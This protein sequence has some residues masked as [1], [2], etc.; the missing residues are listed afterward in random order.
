M[1]S[2]D[3]QRAW[4]P[5]RSFFRSAGCQLSRLETCV[6]LESARAVVCLY[7]QEQRF[8]L[9]SHL[10]VFG[11]KRHFAAMAERT[12]MLS[13][14]TVAALQE[15][16]SKVLDKFDGIKVFMSEM[17]TVSWSTAPSK[18]CK[19]IHNH[20]KILAAIL[21]IASN[22]IVS[23]SFMKDVV[24]NLQNTCRL[25]ATIDVEAYNAALRICLS[26]LRDATAEDEF[27]KMTVRA[28]AEDVGSV[29]RLLK[30]L[31]YRGRSKTFLNKCPAEE[32]AST[33]TRARKERSCT[34][35]KKTMLAIANEPAFK[36]SPESPWPTFSNLGSE[37]SSSPAKAKKT[38]SPPEAA[39]KT[40]S[41]PAPAAKTPP[42]TSRV[43]FVSKFLLLFK[44]NCPN[45]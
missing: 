25:P 31:E 11:S 8:E 32:R 36:E 42:R 6:L 7:V 5:T 39:T 17:K 9:L 23:K 33:P 34:T 45:R 19:A 10:Q 37:P 28:S 24:Q 12:K 40:A 27:R 2:G 30:A 43:Q 15:S 14:V 1:Q 41:L 21:A 35:P 22:G 44:R 20:E 38:P 3:R 13:G 16:M 4:A 26:K 29:K 18:V